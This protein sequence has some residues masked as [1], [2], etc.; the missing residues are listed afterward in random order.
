MKLDISDIAEDFPAY[1][2]GVIVAT[3]LAIPAERPDAFDDEIK[4]RSVEVRERWAGHEL[5]Q[6]PGAFFGIYMPDTFWY[7][8]AN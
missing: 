4:R 6:I 1:R 2:V 7:D 8:D 3:D 5:S